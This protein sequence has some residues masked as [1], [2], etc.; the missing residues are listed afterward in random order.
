MLLFMLTRSQ[1]A[2]KLGKSVATVRRMEGV[3]LNP[4]RDERCFHRFDEREVALVA[5]RIA[6]NGGRRHNCEDGHLGRFILERKL[7]DA[8][9]DLVAI[10]NSSFGESYRLRRQNRELRT[11]LQ[12]LIR[13]SRLAVREARGR[14]DASLARELDELAKVAWSY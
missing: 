3:E 13:V 7:V 9:S 8:H 6:E 1:V 4:V 14:V 12:R 5:R 2:R 11:A 10:G